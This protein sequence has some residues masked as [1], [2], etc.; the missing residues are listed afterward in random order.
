VTAP[1]GFFAVLV[2]IKVD[3]SNPNK[4][5]KAALLAAR[6]SEEIAKYLGK[7]TSTPLREVVSILS[8]V[9]HETEYSH[10]AQVVRRARPG[11]VSLVTWNSSAFKR[12]ASCFA[13]LVLARPMP[14]LSV[15]LP[16]CERCVCAY[17]HPGDQFPTECYG[18][19][20]KLLAQP[21]NGF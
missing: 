19:G 3:P 6:E 20:R 21:A 11:P 18:V 13:S 14:M 7:Y 4:A 17:H 12:A 2:Q 5:I 1:D 8:Q 16:I 15:S 9:L 10:P